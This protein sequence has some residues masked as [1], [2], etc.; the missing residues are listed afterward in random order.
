MRMES[1]RLK[2]I[3]RDLGKA[4][5]EFEYNPYTAM[6]ILDTLRYDGVISI[7]IQEDGTYKY[8]FFPRQNIERDKILEQNLLGHISLGEKTYLITSRQA[9]RLLD[10]DCFTVDAEE[11]LGYTTITY[12]ASDGI[13]T[14]DV[15]VRFKKQIKFCIIVGDSVVMIETTKKRESYNSKGKKVASSDSKTSM[16]NIPLKDFCLRNI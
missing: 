15:N 6:W 3:K 14:E 7:H 10:C 12:T 13:H 5:K 9:E 2:E 1:E 11:D 8:Q 16:T 4:Y